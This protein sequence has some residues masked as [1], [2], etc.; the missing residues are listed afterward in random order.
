MSTMNISWGKGDRCKGL[1]IV[2]IS[3][4][5]K[6]QELLQGLLYL[7]TFVLLYAD[8]RNSPRQ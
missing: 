1:L 5:L 3:V 8:L 7:Y 4:S 6:V 2:L